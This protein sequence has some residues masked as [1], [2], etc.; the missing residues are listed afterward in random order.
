MREQQFVEFVDV[1]GVM[2]VVVQ[3]HGAGIDARFESRVVVQQRWQ[4]VPHRVV[5][6][7]SGLIADAR[8]LSDLS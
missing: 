7:V 5:V 4:H 3:R 2:F 6:V 8:V 1:T